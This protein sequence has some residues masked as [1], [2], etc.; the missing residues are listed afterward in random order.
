MPEEQ[1]EQTGFTVSGPYTQAT[2]WPL[3]FLSISLVRV[4]LSPLMK[5]EGL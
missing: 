3:C 2:G 1:G 5:G 4:V